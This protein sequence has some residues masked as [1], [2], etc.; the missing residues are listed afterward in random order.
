MKERHDR[1][2][3]LLVRAVLGA[4]G[5][6]IPG[7]YRPRGGQ[8]KPGVLGTKSIV[9]QVD[10]NCPTDREVANSRPDM[11]DNKQKY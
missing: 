2:L 3:Y 5:L 1:V 10:R 6:P 7:A 11:V 9:V 4:G 8:A